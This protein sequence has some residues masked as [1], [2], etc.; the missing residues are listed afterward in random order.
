MKAVL[1]DYLAIYE[2][3]PKGTW[4]TKEEKTQR[5]ELLEAYA[6]QSYEVADIDDWYHFILQH[7]QRIELT[8][9][10]FQKMIPALQQDIE[11]GGVKAL[12]LL[13]QKD[14]L[15]ENVDDYLYYRFYR[16]CNETFGSLWDII[17]VLLQREDNY[18]PAL[19]LKFAIIADGIEFTLHE[20]PDAVLLNKD[21]LSE[22]LSDLETYRELGQKLQKDS[23]EIEEEIEEAQFYYRAWGEYLDHREKYDNFEDY[24]AMKK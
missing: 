23:Q 20:L 13:I 9:Q 12:K 10:L 22:A 15:Q 21:Q 14:L 16:I 11:R 5:L 4:L 6:N 24:L 8:V 19:Q 3:F 7:G 2:Q 18:E 1:A 17:A